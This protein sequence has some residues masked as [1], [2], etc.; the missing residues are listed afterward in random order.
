MSRFRTTISLLT[1]CIIAL[2]VLWWL[3]KPEL[4]P[5]ARNEKRA[6]IIGERLDEI[7]EIR[8]LDKAGAPM[9]FKFSGGSW[10]MTEPNRRP[11]DPSA[12]AKLLDIVERAPLLDLI[13]EKE[14]RLRS[15][16]DSDLG[17]DR[18]TGSILLYGPRKFRTGTRITIG[19][20][21]AT[22]NSVFV[23]VGEK[24]FPNDICVSSSEIADIVNEP[25]VTFIDT[26]L[27]RNN[28]RRIHTIVIRSDAGGTV[29]LV[30]D[31]PKSWKITQ[32][33]QARA[34][35]NSVRDLF[36]SLYSARI[37]DLVS[38]QSLTRTETGFDEAGSV[39]LQMF[40]QDIP[41][42]VSLTVG[43]AVAGQPDT[44][45]ARCGGDFSTII[46]TGSVARAVSVSLRDLR[47][48]RIF[49]PECGSDIRSLSIEYGGT[50]ISLKKNASDT[51]NLTSPAA[52][53]ASPEATSKLISSIL[54][55]TAEDVTDSS[56]DAGSAEKAQYAESSPGQPPVTITLNDRNE[57]HI[58]KI[59]EKADDD[60][61]ETKKYS[62]LLDADPSVYELSS[63]QALDYILE[64]LHQPHLVV[65]RTI[66]DITPE[67]I[68]KVERGFGD[69]TADSYT[70]GAG[71]KEVPGAENQQASSLAVSSFF[72]A[73]HP[74][75][76]ESVI[77]VSPYS[78]DSAE[79]T[80]DQSGLS[81]TF[82]FSDGT[83]L[84]KTLIIGP[85]L[86][87]PQKGFYAR[88]KGHS[89]LYS[90]SAETMS[91]LS[92]SF[93]LQV[94]PD[95]ELPSAAPPAHSETG[96]IKNE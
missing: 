9:E 29:K 71:E 3:G 8:I 76:A 54:S 34:D 79:S 82:S 18:P 17:F 69:G 20:F 62:A 21:T 67:N 80:P 74:L 5:Y 43:K 47:D 73:L 33:V 93:G 94:T 58:L 46:V 22:S 45:Y 44:V 6:T 85:A 23:S 65:S 81:V 48:K 75:N 59:S 14:C 16:S 84:Q 12:I 26:R 88:I 78:P 52:A 15:L 87:E 2:T 25:D 61:S 11:A 24:P 60:T 31:T 49:P 72:K 50:T 96:I 36:N 90:I 39:S 56:A 32:P 66:I 27:F 64:C 77:S 38:D 35:W 30:R 68:S 53:A 92:R 51:W 55:L 10:Q 89:A 1:G 70:P 91:L 86:P 13:S 57:R 42:G 4:L 83:S 95:G 37:L 41:A 63:S 28:P 40:G 7:D 19:D